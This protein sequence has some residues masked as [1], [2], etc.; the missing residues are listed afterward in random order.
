MNHA[1]LVTVLLLCALA[2]E[3]CGRRDSP[4]Q[5]SA[6]PAQAATAPAGP[7]G[8]DPG[9]VAGAIPDPALA[10]APAMVG[11]LEDLFQHWV[12]SR[13]E[14]RSRGTAQIFRPAASKEFPPS[15]FR[16]AYKFARDGGCEFYF[17]SPDDGHHFKACRWTISAGNPTIL[18]I[19]A[20]E[21]TTSYR[22]VELSGDVLR[23]MP[24]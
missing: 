19:I 16:M 23:L 8:A 9:P 10:V 5:E 1:F 12:H 2:A 13:E 6:V 7:G 24:R 3:A 17:L 14:E 11:N 22:I 15:R 20:T 21:T 4:P 18:E